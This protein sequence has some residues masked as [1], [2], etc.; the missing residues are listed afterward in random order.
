MQAELNVKWIS[1]NPMS[2]QQYSSHIRNDNEILTAMGIK[3]LESY[4][5][6]QVSWANYH[7]KVTELFLNWPPF[8]MRQRT[9]TNYK[10]CLQLNKTIRYTI[11]AVR[12]YLKLKGFNLKDWERIDIFNMCKSQLKK[13][14]GLLF[15]EFKRESAHAQVENNIDFQQRQKMNRMENKEVSLNTSLNHLIR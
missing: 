15:L 12:N 8:S 4:I 11:S 2:F 3:I 13:T 10:Q 14:C 9:F 1:C 6:M 7:F 5:Y